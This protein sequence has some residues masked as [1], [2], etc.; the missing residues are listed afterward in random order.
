[1]VSGICF[2]F[3]GL[4]SAQPLQPPLRD[5]WQDLVNIPSRTAISGPLHPWRTNLCVEENRSNL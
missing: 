2:D 3:D 4:A 1:M 5:Q